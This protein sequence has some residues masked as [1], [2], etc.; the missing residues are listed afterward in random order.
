MNLLA[1]FARG[2]LMGLAI[3]APVG[4]IG[5]L[6]IQRSLA[7]GRR[8][9]FVSGLGAA[10]AD[11]VYGILAVVG[12]AWLAQGLAEIQPWLRL[13][14]GLFVF[15]LG[16]RLIL[17]SQRAAEQAAALQPGPTPRV[18][19][20]SF[21]A[22]TFA[23]T[24]ANPLTIFSFAAIFA[25]L[26]AGSVATSAAESAA[27][28]GGVFSGS[29]LWWLALSLVAGHPAWRALL[30]RSGRTWI[31]RLA[32]A[33][34]VVFAVT[35]V[36]GGSARSSQPQN[37]LSVVA[38]LSSQ[39]GED[40]SGF[41]RAAPGQALSFPEDFGPHPDFQTEWWYYTGNLA[42]PDGQRYGYQLT[43]FRRALLPP[44]L[45]AARSSTWAVEQIYLAH[46]A[47]SDVPGGRHYSFERT[48]RGAAGLAGAQ[49]SPYSVW[50]DHW[51]VRE[52]EPGRYELFASLPASV[53]QPDRLDH[54]QISL[55]L[56]LVDGKG[57]VLQGI[58]GYSQKGPDPGNASFYYSQT[59]METQG[60][61]TIGT[62]QVAVSGLSWKDHE[63][64][65]SA[66]AASQVGWDWFS[67]QLEDGRELMFFQLRQADGS[68]DPFSSG[69]IVSQDGQVTRLERADFTI[70]VL[71]TWRSPASGGVYP[72]AW[73]VEIPGQDLALEITPLL[74]DQEMDLQYT[75]WEG[76]V[77]VSGQSSRGP[78]N[79]YGYVEMTGYAGV[80]AGE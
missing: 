5:V 63:Y 75:Y 18:R 73:R 61:L 52:L 25:G 57:P 1:I 7:H 47:I 27:L 9:G 59:R 20:L 4:P 46:F 69:S 15:F 45:R 43:F 79:G 49:A 10:C 41:A 68:I 55:R 77:R 62:R 8:A 19:L 44:D 12:L 64:S 76:A 30:G 11:A 35:M 22:S 13:I 50:L 16:V 21:F 56:E 33:I 40:L 72:A 54:P 74:A 42:G 39:A 6:C 23:L 29:G 37:G 36:V 78:L 58:D 28:V 26:G 51:Q 2:L 65:T 53:D 24:L 67:I 34:L 70:T 32:G 48:A 38:G 60:T 66:L 80:I 31:N 3:A 71:D 17:A 14:G